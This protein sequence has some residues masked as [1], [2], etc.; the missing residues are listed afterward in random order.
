MACASPPLP[1]YQDSLNGRLREWG[2]KIRTAASLF[3]ESYLDFTMDSV[4]HPKKA[5]RALQPQ[6]TRELIRA[7]GQLSNHANARKREVQL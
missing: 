6:E 7:R 4:P 1:G 5:W 3:A 2:G